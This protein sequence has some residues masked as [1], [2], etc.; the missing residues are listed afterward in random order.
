MTNLTADEEKAIAEFINRL[1]L[2]EKGEIDTC[3]HCG[4]RIVS[5]KQVGRC[6]YTQPCGCR[7]WQ[8]VVPPAWKAKGGKA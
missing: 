3:P 5:M 6:V 8:G 7:L 1:A 2:L 4:A